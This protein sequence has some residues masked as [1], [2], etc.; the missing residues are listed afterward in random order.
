MALLDW[1]G[2]ILAMADNGFCGVR[3]AV[4]E[5]GFVSAITMALLICSWSAL[6]ICY[7]CTDSA[8]LWVIPRIVGPQPQ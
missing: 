7:V 1:A 5:N 6:F 8:P 4:S 3:M 2:S